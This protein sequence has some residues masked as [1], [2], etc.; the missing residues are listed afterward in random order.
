MKTRT[1]LLLLSLLVSNVYAHDP[2]VSNAGPV[3]NKNGS[4][5]TGI[6]TAQFDP[7]NGILPFPNNLFFLG[8]TDLTLNIPF[9]P[10]DPSADLFRS[11]NALDGF[12]TT[13]RWTAT[14]VDE[15][16]D[17]GAIDPSS[18]KPGVSVRV[19]QVTTAQ[20]VA[21]T[22]IIRELVAGVDFTAVASGNVVAI[23]PLKP[24][25]ELSSFMAVFTN[26]I[27]DVDGNDATPDQTYHLSK[28]H[29]P[30]V[31]AQGNSTYPL[32]DNPTAQGLE[33]LRQITNS[34]EFAA[35]AAGIDHE[36]IILAWTVQTQSITPSLKLLRSIAQPAPVLAAPTGLNTTAAGGFGLADIVIGVITIP[37]YLGIPSEANPVAPLTDFWTA[38]PGGYIPPCSQ[39]GLDPTSTNVTAC[40]PFPVVTGMQTIPFFMTVPNENSGFEKPAEGWPVV[41]YQH[42]ITRNRTDLLAVADA[43]ASAGFAAIAIDQ[44]L[45]GVVPAVAPQL[46]PFYIENT[47]FGALANERT[48]DADYWNN[49]TGAPVPDGIPDPSGTSSFNL[50]SLRTARDN[51]RQA[52]ADL[53]VLAVS[54]QNISVDGDEI[55]DLN[56]FN[57]GVAIH[58]LGTTV[59]IGF[60]AIEPVLSRAYLNAGTG[61]IIRTGIAGAFGVRINAGLAAAGIFPGSTEYEQFL[62]VAQTV[63]DSGDGINWATEAGLRG[64]VI[65]NI[66]IGDD[67]VPNAVPG[68]PIAGSVAVNRAMGLSQYSATTVNPEGLKGFARFTSGIHSSLISP[69]GDPAVTAEMQGQLASFMASGGTLVQ[70]NNPTV[71]EQVMGLNL[72]NTNR[73]ADSPGG[74]PKSKRPPAKDGGP[75]PE[76][77]ER[78]RE[79]GGREQ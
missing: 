58:S 5:V 28:A 68:A 20:I 23:I 7:S 53:S 8:T 1:F 73:V 69:A 19:F 3:L 18:V 55:P 48:F 64:S 33:S 50:F 24:L 78:P 72:A 29:S 6:L 22:G 61:A 52:T 62:T 42:G 76:V 15:N 56:P 47:P 11:L 39:F 32:L 65:H 79:S 57:V 67:T 16:G 75:R 35:A 54:L 2:S 25:P 30:W 41:I 14:F 4:V 17:P 38:P 26:D 36:D 21:V 46:A 51:L 70:V 27:R 77:F 45:H 34:M 74:G 44:P 9:D 31:D 59:G 66:V 63:L 43:L 60:Y 49:T 13:E 37:Y 12:S 40:N 71:L 10:T